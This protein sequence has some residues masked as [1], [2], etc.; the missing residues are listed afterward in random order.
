M[1]STS[2]SLPKASLSRK[3]IE[4]LIAENRI[5]IYFQPIISVDRRQTLI[6]EALAR[7]V[8]E[9]GKTMIPPNILFESAARAE[10]SLEFDRACR[11]VAITNFA[12][13]RKKNPELLLSLN[14]DSAVI[15][16]T[17]VGSGFLQ[18]KIAE[19]NLDCS[20]VII[21]I[22]E[23]EVEDTDI[24][25]QFTERHR[26]LGF[27]VA[28]DDIGAGH[29]NFDRIPLLKP[30]IIKID[31]SLVRAISADYHKQEVVKA[32]TDMAHRLG[33]LVVAEGIE[34]D[35]EALTVHELGADFQQG[36]YFARPAPTDGELQP[37]PAEQIKTVSLKFKTLVKARHSLRRIRQERNESI[38]ARIIRSLEPLPESNYENALAEEAKS[39]DSLEC[40]YVT[41]SQGVMLTNTVIAPSVFHQRKQI[42]HPAQRGTD[43][44]LKDYCLLLTLG[45]ERYTSDPYISQATGNTCITISQQFTALDGKPRFLCCDIAVNSMMH[46]TY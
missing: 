17:V 16:Q 22:L 28:I 8:A 39:D 15:K 5:C 21:E 35:Q 42:F 6:V 43:L 12:Q 46:E 19:A 9:D 14:I 29:S 20:S 7:G 36:F 10:L 44:S 11:A 13:L 1:T 37:V 33:G 27:L 3:Q 24:L 26:E 25:R 34:D 23:N 2:V 4:A 40:L 45:L 38:M 18:R 30:D 41:D 31:R 32:L